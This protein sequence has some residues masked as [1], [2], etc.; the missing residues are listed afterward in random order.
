MPSG[1]TEVD[2]QSLYQKLVEAVLGI[3]ELG[4]KSRH[5]ITFLFPSDLMTYG[6]GEEIIVEIT[7]LYEKPERTKQ[8]Q[9][10]LAQAVG[11]VIKDAYPNANVEVFV[12]TFNP[13]ASGFWQNR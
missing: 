6:L 3:A 9:D 13:A 11:Q 5:D 12:Y 10:H 4:L 8:V 7:G 1:Q 2:L